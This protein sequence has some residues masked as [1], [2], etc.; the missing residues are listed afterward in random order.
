VDHRTRASDFIPTLPRALQP[1]PSH[2]LG[3]LLDGD[4]GKFHVFFSVL[5]IG[6]FL[7]E[8]FS[9]RFRVNST[10]APGPAANCRTPRQPT[11]GATLYVLE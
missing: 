4:V 6:A 3:R 8:Y 10:A 7:Q 5:Y 1:D 2:D 11:A 9:V